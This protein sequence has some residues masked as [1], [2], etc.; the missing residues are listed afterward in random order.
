VADNLKARDA[1]TV[2]AEDVS[3]EVPVEQR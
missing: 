1:E 2:A 3:D